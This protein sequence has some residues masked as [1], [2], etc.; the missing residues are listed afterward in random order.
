MC[1]MAVY[2]FP[3][4]WEMHLRFTRSEKQTYKLISSLLS[5]FFST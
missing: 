4:G 1:L 5:F 3:M 2:S